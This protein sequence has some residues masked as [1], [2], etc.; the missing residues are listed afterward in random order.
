MNSELL[1]AITN[2][3]LALLI[4]GINI[5]IAYLISYMK[6]KAGV[7]TLKQIE[8]EIATKHELAR[9]AILFAQQVFKE[10]D[11]P[12]KYQKALTKLKELLD[13]YG[14]DYTEEELDAIIHGV[15]KETK[16]TFAEEWKKQI[17]SSS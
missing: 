10:F 3:L 7:E 12:I 5:G 1:E 4:A 8:S 6:N 16:M 14:F 15:L 9:T 17:G 2:G 13:P 11:G